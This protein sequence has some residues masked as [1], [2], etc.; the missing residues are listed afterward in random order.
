MPMK[1]PDKHYRSTKKDPQYELTFIECLPWVGE[2]P[3]VSEGWVAEWFWIPH[4]QNP[5]LLGS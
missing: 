4:S 1:R 5:L 2:G 3:G